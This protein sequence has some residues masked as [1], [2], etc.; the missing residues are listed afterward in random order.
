MYCMHCGRPVP[1]QARFCPACGAQLAQQLS[2]KKKKPWRILLIVFLSAAVLAAVGFGIA[3]RLDA[4]PTPAL[5]SDEAD[6]DDTDKATLEQ[7]L[8]A[9]SVHMAQMTGRCAGSEAY[10]A[11]AQTPEE[12][13]G[14]VKNFSL[15]AEQP[16]RVLW[17][18]ASDFTA[19][20]PDAL[21]A[22]VP[23]QFLVRSLAP[24]LNGRFVGSGALAAAGAVSCTEQAKLPEA[25]EEPMLF[26]VKYNVSEGAGPTALVVAVPLAGRLTSFS[27]QPI[28]PDVFEQAGLDKL[29]CWIAEK[30]DEIGQ[31]AAAA[32][33][34]SLRAVA[35]ANL[36]AEPAWYEQQARA[37]LERFA[38]VDTEEVP[39]T[40]S[41]FTDDT[42]VVESASMFVRAAA[43]GS[44]TCT[45]C[46]IDPDRLW[47]S[48]ELSEE[49]LA[50]LA[51]AG[52]EELFYRRLIAAI[53]NRLINAYGTAAAAAAAV[54][55]QIPD[56]V[57]APS[58]AVV[59][60][61]NFEP[62]AAVFALN[63]GACA[64]VMLFDSGNGILG[65][66]VCFLPSCETIDE[67]PALLS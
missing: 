8:L 53:P 34:V 57:Q 31:A 10:L 60:P 44:D 9:Q 6:E 35:P 33:E 1:G 64:I 42:A 59:L 67:L 49:E 2:E 48:A 5:A 7:V 56:F 37:V 51:E 15:L 11:A 32:E 36:T 54:A 43:A 27:C 14:Y 50:G 3:K 19:A 28:F 23:E 62:Q 52:L 17:C 41:L 38:A 29:S 66:S 65:E 22:D 13:Y 45:L 18:S 20:Y 58:T 12:I 39:A 61:E 26:A 25:L 30:S 21:G 40:V 46:P 24:V 63:N 4:G 55:V 47:A 16:N